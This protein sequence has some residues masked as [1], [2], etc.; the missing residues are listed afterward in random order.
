MIAG[1]E[2]EGYD[3]DGGGVGG[4]E[5]EKWE[6]GSCGCWSLKDYGSSGEEVAGEGPGVSE[7]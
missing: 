3:D 1:Y 5:W 7:V 4:S 6:S 2:T